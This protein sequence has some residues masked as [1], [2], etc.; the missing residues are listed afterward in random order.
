MPAGMALYILTLLVIT[1][2]FEKK[3]KVKKEEI[4]IQKNKKVK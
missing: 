2:A 3:L 4:E 1:N